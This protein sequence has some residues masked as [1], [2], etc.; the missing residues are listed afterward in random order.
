MSIQ[1]LSTLWE[2]V[3]SYLYP[4]HS[5][6]IACHRHTTMNGRISGLC[7]R[8][9]AAIPWIYQSVCKVCGRAI[10]CPD[11]R[12]RAF[13]DRYFTFNRSA[14]QYDTEMRRWLAEYKY[15]GNEGYTEVIGGILKEGYYRMQQEMTSFYRQI[16]CPDLITWVPAS[17]DRLVSRGFDQAGVMADELAKAIMV[18]CLPLL[19]RNRH[20]VKQSTQDR[21]GRMQN[22]QGVFSYHPQA[23][24]WLLHILQGEAT[25]SDTSPSSTI[26]TGN[27]ENLCRILLIDD[28]YTTG[29]TINSCA[30]ALQQAVAGSRITVEVCSLT[31][32]RS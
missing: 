28:I 31:W 23:P 17:P 32:S 12:R 18:P 21:R 9:A 15:S 11:C 20:T 19:I 26:G 8:C 5:A 10:D 24:E 25:L 30:Q 2:K 27:G 14:V 3:L 6:C 29:S 4:H 13:A 1:Q 16:W 7:T 22:V